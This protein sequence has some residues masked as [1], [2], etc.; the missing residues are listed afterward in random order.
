MANEKIYDFSVWRNLNIRQKKQY[1]EQIRK[2]ANRR[3]RRLRESGFAIPLETQDY[4]ED[5]EKKFFPSIKNLNEEWKV[6]SFLLNAER[7]LNNRRSTITGT[8]EVISEVLTSIE[9]RL[10]EFREDKIILNYGSNEGKRNFYNFL[11]SQQFKR[12]KR[13]IDSDIAIQEYNDALRDGFSHNEILKMFSE[14]ME[15]ELSLQEM[16]MERKSRMDELNKRRIESM[17]RRKN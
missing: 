14:F 1:Y 2:T 11:H 16:Q 8:R 10:N 7:F 13:D 15:S 17:E 3:I 9:N 12:L 4:L 6:N 5:L